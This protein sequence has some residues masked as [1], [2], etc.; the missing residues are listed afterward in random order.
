MYIYYSEGQFSQY[1]I[2]F[3]T[4]LNKYLYTFHFFFESLVTICH[5][6]HIVN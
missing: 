2:M 1:L 6:F 4:C 3:D 5:V